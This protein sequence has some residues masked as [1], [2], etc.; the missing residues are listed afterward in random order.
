MNRAI[1]DLET[2]GFS[3]LKDAVVEIGIIIINDKYEVL[4]DK[5]WIIK[6]YKCGINDGL[7][8]YR[9]EA[10]AINGISMNEIENG[11]E[12]ES[13]CLELMENL[14]AHNI[15]T[16]IGHNLYFDY[17]RLIYIIGR[18]TDFKF[19]YER[20][21]TLNESKKQGL[22][23]ESDSLESLCKHFA[24]TNNDKHRALG[25]CYATL[26]LLKKLNK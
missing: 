5:S 16:I 7:V 17:A 23:L 18:F 19:E 13:V 4:F 3:I 22:N 10:M 1:I 11:Y 24:I 21:D 2:G 26:E 9:E 25:D 15:K 6:P 8:R 14:Q 20:L 12:V